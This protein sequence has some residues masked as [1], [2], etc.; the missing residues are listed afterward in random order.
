MGI[1]SNLDLSADFKWINRGTPIRDGDT[2]LFG[3]QYQGYPYAITGYNDYFLKSLEGADVHYNVTINNIDTKACVVSSDNSKYK[4]DII[5]NTG[6]TDEV[7]GFKHGKLGYSGR[8]IIPIVLL[9]NMFLI[10]Q[11]I[12]GLIILVTNLIPGQLTLKK[13]QIMNLKAAY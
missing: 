8:K 5:I 6:H 7:F 2:R 12:I 11:N 4:Y 13:L 9:I 3:D 10:I 1:D